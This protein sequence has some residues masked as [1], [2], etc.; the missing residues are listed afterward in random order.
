MTKE[1]PSAQRV[2]GSEVEYSYTQRGVEA[3]CSAL[4]TVASLIPRKMPHIGDFLGN[5]GRLYKDLD[6]VEYATPECL[7][8]DELVIHELAGENFALQAFGGIEE[9][10]TVHKR[11]IDTVGKFTYG[12]H[13]NYSTT[14]DVWSSANPDRLRRIQ[15]LATH[16]ATRTIYT[17]A[18]YFSPEGVY[19]LGQ[20]TS[21]VQ[22]LSGIETTRFKP[23]VNLRNEPHDG[24]GSTKR[25]HVTSGDANIS[26]WAIRMKFGTTSLVLRLLEHELDWIG[27][28]WLLK[29][30]LEVAVNVAGGVDNLKAVYEINDGSYASAISIQRSL[31]NKCLAMA[32]IIAIPD[33]E[34]EVLNEWGRVLD[35]LDQYIT[36]GVEDPLLMQI[37]WY[38][39]LK[40][41]KNGLDRSRSNFPRDRKKHERDRK[42]YE[43]GYDMLPNGAGFGLR[44]KGRVFSA[45]TPTDQQVEDALAEPPE[46]RAKLRGRLVT[47][48]FEDPDHYYVSSVNWGQLSVN[49][50][51]V[52]LPLDGNYSDDVVDQYLQDLRAI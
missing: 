28:N 49:G 33:H 47:S 24:S 8:L 18:G 51:R 12:A 19:H 44:R 3:G 35:A 11:A 43:I 29:K 13:E 26:P 52:P 48:A 37:D 41:V 39:R 5:G 10:Q 6:L 17:G 1:M 16:F 34:R 2:Y 38:A 32:E 23:L 22:S 21:R 45:H 9:I 46:G 31:F 15:K 42:K 36:V 50:R 25:L 30:P 27:Q 7:S 14:L 40:V 4:T 20:K